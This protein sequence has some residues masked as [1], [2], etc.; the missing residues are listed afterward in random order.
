MRQRGRYARRQR[1]IQPGP[2]Q[3]ALVAHLQPTIHRHYRHPLREAVEGRLEQG[4]AGV[5]LS[6]SGLGQQPVTDA[7]LMERL[8]ERPGALAHLF[9]QQRGMLEGRIG[10]TTRQIAR[11]H[12]LDQRRIDALETLHLLHQRRLPLT[13]HVASPVGGRPR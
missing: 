4:L 9:G 8:I 5:L 2:G 12:A 7:Q 10:S 13:N 3:A 1:L 6:F 11:L